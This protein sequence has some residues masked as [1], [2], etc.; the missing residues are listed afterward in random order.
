MMEILIS[1][2]LMIVI[3][4]I[5][6]FWK[7]DEVQMDDT[8]EK[9]VKPEEKKEAEIALSGD[10]GTVEFVKDALTKLGCQYDVNEE[11][12]RIGF[13]FQGGYFTINV[14]NDSMMIIIYFLHWM[15]HNIEDIDGFSDLRRIINEC[16]L[17]SNVTTVY[18]IDEEENK[19]VVH[20]R[21]RIVFAPQ[22][23][24]YEI[25]LK[26]MLQS[27]FDASSYVT[28]EFYTTRQAEMDKTN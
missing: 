27:F 15:D 13:M 5:L 21:K 28:Y 22:I 7:K 1:L 23:P 20:S 17:S 2:T 8:E 16:N 3:S 4:V 10:F 26:N 14:A 18:T 6:H 19:V 24:H 12:G 9:E 25:Y 11:G